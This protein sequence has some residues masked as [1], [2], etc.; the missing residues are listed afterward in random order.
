MFLLNEIIE[1][2]PNLYMV[3]KFFHEDVVIP[4]RKG[5]VVCIVDMEIGI[6]RNCDEFNKNAPKEKKVRTL[7]ENV[8]RRGEIM[9]L[10]TNIVK[11]KK[12][13]LRF[14]TVSIKVRFPGDVFVEVP[15]HE[16]IRKVN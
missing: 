12:G 7:F 13:L 4:F 3:N 1:S 11:R 2:V 5:D 14:K 15:N 6:Y 16:F 8:N 9:E 10:R